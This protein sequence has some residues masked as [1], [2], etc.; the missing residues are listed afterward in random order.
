MSLIPPPPQK[1]WA[2]RL[3]DRPTWTLTGNAETL[4]VWTA[5]G[6][7]TEVREYA[8]PDR[9]GMAVMDEALNGMAR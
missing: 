9:P 1:I 6:A 4:R 2:V 7:A 3:W 8:P 5:N